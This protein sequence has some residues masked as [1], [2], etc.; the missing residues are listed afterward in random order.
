L[1]HGVT[2]T[3]SFLVNRLVIGTGPAL[4]WFSANH[5]WTE[6]MNRRRGFTFIELLVV[7]LFLGALSSIAVPRF[8]E[9]KTRAFIAAMQS[10]LGNL[11]IAQESYWAD[12]QQY[13]TDTTSLG[14]KTT[15]QVAISIT[16]EDAIG[17]YTAIA[18]HP[19]LPG[20]QCE[21]AMGKEAAP[22]EPGSIT[23]GP[24]TSGSSAIPTP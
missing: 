23:C 14:L 19:N 13:A 16:S 12:H 3:K 8:R 17:G 10:D 18:T 11:R 21:T 9:Y 2:I 22:R 6:E 4:G 15:A 20:K 24:T 1:S 7:M 5:P